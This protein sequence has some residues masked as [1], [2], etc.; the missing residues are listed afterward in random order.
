[1]AKPKTPSAIFARSSNWQNRSWTQYEPDQLVYWVANLCM[2]AQN[3]SV[4]QSEKIAKDMFDAN[5][6]LSMLHEMLSAAQIMPQIAARENEFVEIY[7]I[8]TAVRDALVIDRDNENTITNVSAVDDDL[9]SAAGRALSK[10]YEMHQN[11]IDTIPT[12]AKVE[13]ASKIDL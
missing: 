7:D 2:R 8:A 10:L 9:A 12:T 13:Y 1:M 5:N 4:E 11:G 6:Y 3:R